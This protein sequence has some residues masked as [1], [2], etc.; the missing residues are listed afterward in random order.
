METNLCSDC[1]RTMCARRCSGYDTWM[2]GCPNY[3]PPTKINWQVY[4]YDAPR[5]RVDAEQTEATEPVFKWAPE[6]CFSTTPPQEPA[7]LPRPVCGT[8]DQWEMVRTGECADAWL[9]F[10]SNCRGVDGNS[11]ACL[12]HQDFPAYRES[13]RRK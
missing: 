10:T 7:P 3:R 6:T 12:H 4:S 5:P 1:R 13:R 9:C 8:C 11:P 2:V